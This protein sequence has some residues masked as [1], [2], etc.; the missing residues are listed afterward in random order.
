MGTDCVF[1]G[2]RAT[3]GS[4]PARRPGPLWPDQGPGGGDRARLPHPPDLHHRPRTPG[5]AGAGRMVSGPTR[6]G[7][8]FHP[9]HLQRFSHRHSGADHEGPGAGPPGIDRLYHVAAPPISKYELLKLVAGQYGRQIEITPMPPWQWT[10]PWM[11]RPSGRL[12]DMPPR[13]AGVGGRNAPALSRL[14]FL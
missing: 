12:P 9:G 1:D 7:A 14:R 10:A 11:P 2:A 13:L 3:I 4:G 8:G 6:R 5:Q